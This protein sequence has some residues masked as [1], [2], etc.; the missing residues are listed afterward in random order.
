M[1]RGCSLGGAGGDLRLT[2]LTAKGHGPCPHNADQLS[3]WLSSVGGIDDPPFP[4]PEPRESSRVCTIRVMGW[5]YSPC[6]PVG[7]V[8]LCP[9]GSLYGE[10]PK[11]S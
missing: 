9:G 5:G 3:T 8:C 2:G 7:A 4:K 6:R 1:H 11:E 10:G